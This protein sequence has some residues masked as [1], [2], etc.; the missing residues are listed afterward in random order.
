MEVVTTPGALGNM[1]GVEL[2]DNPI[3]REFADFVAA[4]E[5][6][7]YGSVQGRGARNPM[8]L[9]PSM[10]VSVNQQ[11]FG[12]PACKWNRLRAQ[13]QQS[14]QVRPEWLALG[15]A[16]WTGDSDPKQ[17]TMA[18][19]NGDLNRV[20]ELCQE[21]RE[22]ADRQAKT[23]LSRSYKEWLEGSSAGGLKPLFRALKKKR[24]RQGHSEH[25]IT[26]PECTPGWNSGCHFGK[27]RDSPCSRTTP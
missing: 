4:A 26:C 16:H 1:A 15:L 12:A 27:P 18:V 23:A 19:N 10:Q 6:A 8:I 22:E 24:R 25:W 21:Q 7:S 2:P 17:W 11:W 20:R 14:T 9:R 3:T 13:V 5:L